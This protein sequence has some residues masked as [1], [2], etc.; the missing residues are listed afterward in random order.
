MKFRI[1]KT[2]VLGIGGVFSSQSSESSLNEA[3]VIS[4]TE[5]I[6]SYLAAISAVAPLDVMPG[7]KDP[8]GIMLPQK[9]FHYCE[10]CNYNI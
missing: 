4:A 5:C 9:P 6:D 2:S 3:A 8:T 10:L 7:C 1:Y